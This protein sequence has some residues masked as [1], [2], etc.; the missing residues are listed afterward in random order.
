MLPGMMLWYRR[1][2]V[3]VGHAFLIVPKVDM[4]ETGNIVATLVLEG[5]FPPY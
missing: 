1:K 2:G 3:S 5:D 4:P